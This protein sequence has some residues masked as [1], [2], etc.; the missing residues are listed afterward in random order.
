MSLGQ[1]TTGSISGTVRDD[2]GAVLP[3]TAISTK[4]L[5]TGT[6]RTG[7]TDEHG[8]YIISQLALGNY[9]VQ[10]ELPGFQTGIRTGIRLT[11]GREAI[12]DFTLAVGEI[13]EKIVVTGEA[14]LV[15]TARS[16][17]SG[18][19]EEKT[20]RDLPLNGRSFDQL[21]LLH[22]GVTSSR[23]SG[24]GA[25]LVGFGSFF[26]VSGARP[27]QNS[28]LLDGTDINNLIDQPGSVAGVLLGVDAVREFEILTTNYSA[29]YGRAAG[30]IIS[31]ATRS[32]T[33]EFHGSVF[34][35]H[36]NDN[37]DARN[38]FDRRPNPPEFK[39]N[40][41]GFAAGG[42]IVRNRTFVL[43]TYEGLRE[44][45]GLTRTSI[46]PDARSRQGLLPDPARPGQFINVGV[47]PAVRPFLDLYPLPTGA[48]FGDGTGPFG[49]SESQPT[50]EDFFQIRMDHTLSNSHSLF[51]RYT[52][53]DGRLVR[54]LDF[55][56][57]RSRFTTANQFVTLEDKYIFS[58]RLLNV[59]RFGFNR[60]LILG[61]E[62]TDESTPAGVTFIP[63]R[64]LGDILI[65]GL[66]VVGSDFTL[67]RRNL[68][69]LFEWTDNV[70]YTTGRHSLKLGFNAKR[71][72]ANVIQDLFRR[73]RY[74]FNSL[75]DFLAS[76]P[77]FF[78]SM[79]LDAD[80]VRGFRQSLFG[81]YVQ[82]DIRLSSNLTLNL[83][84][85]YEVVTKPTEKNGK[86]VHL[87]S[88]FAPNTVVGD[89][90]LRNP[91]LRNLAPRLG[92]A[93]DPFRDGKTSLRGGFG[94]FYEQILPR[95]YFI[96]SAQAPPFFNFAIIPGVSFPRGGFEAITGAAPV[97]NVN[98]L[99]PFIDTPYTIQWNLNLQRQL[100]AN[101]VFSI[102]YV[103]A[104][105]VKLTTLK[106]SNTAIPQVLPDGRKFFPLGAPRRNP[107]FASL[108]I[109]LGEA[110]SFYHSLQLGFNKRYAETPIG[111]LQF[112]VSHTLS[113]SVDDHTADLG[114]RFGN[115]PAGIQDADHLK[116]DRGL[117]NFD[118]RQ[119]LT[120]NYTY[121]IPF[122]KGLTGFANK[123]ATGW[124]ING[125][126][127]VSSGI[128][129]NVLLGFNRSRSLALGFRLSDRPD[130][131]PGSS[132]NPT[133]GFRR[134]E[135]WFDRNAFELQPAGFFGNLGRDT[136]IGP[137]FVNF[138]F[139]VVKNNYVRS[140]SESFNVQFRAE[141]FNIFNRPN[142]ATPKNTAG[143]TG[144]VIIFNDPSGRPLGSAGQIFDTVSTSRQ[145]QVGLK[146]VW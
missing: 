90:L 80:S 30:G 44:R 46:T 54:P 119:N 100:F 7:V 112:Q 139:S 132:N 55:P 57:Y 61:A 117:S 108:F 140:I 12:V 94:I 97:R 129:F 128:P 130:L 135:Q 60:S 81:S 39:R 102:G 66:S 70:T 68:Q 114:G 79:F 25:I 84:L 26:S 6:T 43:G 37:L 21:A 52:F 145:I 53:D 11:L 42:P 18:L 48:D 142:F 74:Q 10:A 64:P 104:R 109:Y 38:F 9:E 93:W 126:T 27:N 33:N 29:E 124:Q 141:F 62:V 136:V 40:Q 5:E 58:P 137:G 89:I 83:G 75:G 138:D 17:I 133:K 8:R 98:G 24:K 14:P 107:N 86:E 36:R 88:I 3:G 110:N 59:F 101:A 85:R 56:T 121:E 113:K 96:A 15:D 35:F 13:T 82:D 73:G 99:D 134:P 131:K 65:G 22:P 19:V 78:F 105:G 95:I 144:G 1:V 120:I 127:T 116:G 49:F 69:N 28:Y 23:Q 31:A 91:S 34:A 67:P 122:G 45:L 71:F 125:I 143:G 50:D 123:M 20:I 146:I 16:A 92:F 47:S 72:Q 51:G 103:G 106:E 4:H 41:F 32:G 77:V 76:R 115:A 63:G 87:P 2:T 118:L 111:P